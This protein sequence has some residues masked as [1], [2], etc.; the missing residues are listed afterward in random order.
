MR[1]EH[2][3]CTAV[4]VTALALTACEKSTPG[5][6]AS[7][8]PT[9]APTAPTPTQDLL[10]VALYPGLET[11]VPAHPIAGSTMVESTFRSADKA[12]LIAAFYRERLGKIYGEATQ[13]METGAGEGMVRLAAASSEGQNIEVMVRPDGEGA[14]VGIR[15]FGKA[16]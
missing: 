15:S 14:I 12:P 10:G 5:G 11:L 13:F 8:V 16:N 4:I 3:A 7:G 2:L 9:A 6:G 1:V